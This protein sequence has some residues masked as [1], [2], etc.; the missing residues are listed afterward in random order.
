MN[1]FFRQSVLSELN[2]D[3][4]CVSETHCIN[5]EIIYVP[6]YKT[7]QLNRKEPNCRLR[8]SGGVAIFIRDDLFKYHKVLSEY[9]CRDGLLSLKLLNVETEAT[10]GIISNYLSPDSYKYGKNP[11]G[12]FNDLSSLWTDL[13]DCDL[14]IGGGDLNSRTKTSPDYIADID[15]NVP[16]RQNPDQTENNHENISYSS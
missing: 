3:I 5:D 14:L 12:Y 8:G 1:K 9:K 2:L 16:P 13:S 15:G 10:V 4:Y 6:N 7:F 11:E